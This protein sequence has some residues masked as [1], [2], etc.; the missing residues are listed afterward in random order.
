M[1]NDD[2]TAPTDIDE[3]PPALQGI[4]GS[5]RSVAG[6]A[7]RLSAWVPTILAAWKAG[8]SAIAVSSALHQQVDAGEPIEW[9]ADTAEEFVETLGEIADALPAFDVAIPA[10]S[11]LVDAGQEVVDGDVAADLIL[12]LVG[13]LE[14][15][16][17]K[18]LVV[19]LETAFFAPKSTDPA[20]R[21][22]HLRRL[23]E[24]LE[25]L[26]DRLLYLWLFD[27]SEPTKAP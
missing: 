19:L 17:S 3:L 1:S 5:L 16:A 21:N 25:D 20:R 4:F 11:E 26:F 13:R 18:G 7:D 10:T 6:D 9:P 2:S 27:D 14:T 22:K 15:L 24:R 23:F 8:K 12:D